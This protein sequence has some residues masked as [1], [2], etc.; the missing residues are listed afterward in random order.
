MSSLNDSTTVQSGPTP[1][2]TIKLNHS[3]LNDI[4]RKIQNNILANLFDST[5]LQV[6]T[7]F[8]TLSNNYSS[9]DQEL[10][11]RFVDDDD[12]T[13]LSTWKNISS[14]LSNQITESAYDDDIVVS[15]IPA[16]N[17]TGV[18]FRSYINSQQFEKKILIASITS[19]RK[20]S[21][22]LMNIRLSKEEPISPFKISPTMTVFNFQRRQRI[23]Y[24]FNDPELSDWR[25][26][27]TL[28]FMTTNPTDRKLSMKLDKQ[29]IYDLKEYDFIDLEFEYIGNYKNVA[30]SFFK[31]ISTI[32]PVYIHY[33]PIFCTIC[34]VLETDIS[35]LFPILSSLTKQITEQTKLTDY[36]ISCKYA[37]YHCGLID[38][39]NC[40]YELTDKSFT[41]IIYKDIPEQSHLADIV[42]KYT[43]QNDYPVHIS[44]FDA[45]CVDDGKYIITDCLIYKSN[46]YN[47]SEFVDRFNFVK[48]YINDFTSTKITL[49]P[50]TI[51]SLRYKQWGTLMNNIRKIVVKNNYANGLILRI[52]N[53]SFTNPI[54]YKL[55]ADA[56]ETI[57]FKIMYSKYDK[58]YHLYVVG[59]VQN[60]LSKDTIFDSNYMR[61]FGYSL[62][63]LT[64][65][66]LENKHLL[67]FT[68]PFI[69]N[70]HQYKPQYIES[71]IFN[72]S[73]TKSINKIVS[74]LIRDPESISGHIVEFTLYDNTWVPIS[75]REDKSLPNTYEDAINIIS[76]VYTQNSK[77]IIP[78]S[79]ITPDEN[80]INIISKLSQTAI[81]CSSV[82]D[83][84]V[85]EN[86]MA[87]NGYKSILHIFNSPYVN[88]ADMISL[89]KID[90]IYAINEDRNLLTQY[91]QNA[92]MKSNSHKPFMRYTDVRENT[93]SLTINVINLKITSS[94]KDI[95]HD[96][97]QVNTYVHKSVD[98]V[99]I[100]D[101]FAKFETIPDILRFKLLCDQILSPNGQIVVKYMDSDKLKTYINTDESSTIYTDLDM[102]SFVSPE[103]L[104]IKFA[105]VNDDIP[106]IPYVRYSDETRIVGN[107]IYEYL[108]NHDSLIP[109][110]ENDEIPESLSLNIEDFKAI[111]SFDDHVFEIPIPDRAKYLLSTGTDKEINYLIQSLYAVDVLKYK[112]DNLLTAVQ[113]LNLRTMFNIRTEYEASIET[114]VLDK[115]YSQNYDI[116]YHLGAI[117]YPEDDIEDNLLIELCSIKQHKKLIKNRLVNRQY[118]TVIA[119]KDKINISMYPDV[120]R[121]KLT[122]CNLYIIPSYSIMYYVESILQY[123]NQFDTP[124]IEYIQ[125]V[126]FENKCYATKTNIDK[127]FF[128]ILSDTWEIKSSETAI[129][130]DNVQKTMA[131]DICFS[132]IRNIETYM[133]NYMVKVLKRI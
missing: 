132:K 4:T 7:L 107:G 47:S 50:A 55:K 72:T 43:I 15:W 93:P 25:I 34:T 104:D 101:A 114:A 89:S 68:C 115:W 23:S 17:I 108:L 106:H 59:Y 65:K 86:I 95:L 62:L 6:S 128:N 19:S 39:N 5:S 53:S 60:S 97:L 67:L 111:I 56:M 109:E 81:N 11:F 119:T 16:N 74:I 118:T 10:E 131:S 30:E 8:E 130:N 87:N 127:L 126:D 27:K 78:K 85:V 71:D 113:K 51:L 42:K 52:N 20:S 125:H 45:I 100:Q 90:Y 3:D 66:E 96:L 77:H 32:I 80:M 110:I 9:I 88:V 103:I 61:Y 92:I 46:I 35:K 29:N 122:E 69:R 57:D 28:R 75:I 133:S 40:I 2:Q 117:G 18:H 14:I 49:L 76:S 36:I 21:N 105:F 1:D 83:Q 31:L 91:V 84:Y 73:L 98:C 124:I 94:I 99:Y 121:F 58:L 116:E 48:E 102:F 64:K 12:H 79:I 22:P 44:I 33:D 24:T 123:M 37:G 63:T 54:I 129:G 26:D 13:S 70:L 82:F 38:F 112:P 120:Y 41:K